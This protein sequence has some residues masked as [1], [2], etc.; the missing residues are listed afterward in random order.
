MVSQLQVPVRPNYVVRERY[1]RVYTSYFAAEAKVQ[2]RLPNDRH[3]IAAVRYFPRFAKS[4]RYR[5]FPLLA[6]SKD[7][8]ARAKSERMPFE[9]YARLYLEEI[10]TNHDAMHL[11]KDLLDL[12]LVRKV[13]LVLFCYE[14]DSVSC[15]RTLL[16]EMI[17][18]LCANNI[19][20]PAHIFDGGEI[21]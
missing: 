12:L 2:R 4:E 18:N 17:V 21:K 8:L 14:K 15:H 3:F 10:T 9:N 16:K 13:D 6:P 5:W 20:E 19:G 1:G 11:V 7:L